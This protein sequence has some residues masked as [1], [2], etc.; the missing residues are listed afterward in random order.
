MGILNWLPLPLFLVIICIKNNSP[1]MKKSGRRDDK[2][3]LRQLRQS[4]H[5]R[6]LPAYLPREIHRLEPEESCCPECGGELDYLGEVS[7]EQ[8]ELVSSALKVIRTER[9]KKA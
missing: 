9:V 6:P 2:L 4:H 7:A 1:M 5:R 3:V 8:L